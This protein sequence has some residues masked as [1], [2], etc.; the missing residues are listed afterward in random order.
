MTP[1]VFFW[2]L[3]AM[4]DA[5]VIVGR[6]FR[7]VAF[8]GA[9]LILVGFI[10]LI[11]AAFAG[12]NHASG[13]HCER[14]AHAAKAKLAAKGWLTMGWPAEHGGQGR[15]LEEMYLFQEACNEVGAPKATVAVQQVGPTLRQ[16]GT[17]EQKQRFLPP[18]ARGDVEF[19]LGYTEPDSGTD[20][21]SRA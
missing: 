14:D 17:E 9:L 19:A 3:A 16:F 1:L 11:T 4:L 12:G 7:K 6:G 21:A 2:A 5:R 20:L 8:V 18:I 13:D 15:S 10:G